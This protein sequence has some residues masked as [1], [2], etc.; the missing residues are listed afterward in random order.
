MQK[1]LRER[2]V[3]GVDEL[4]QVELERLDQLQLAHWGKAMAGNLASAKVVLGIIEQ[5][6]RLLGLAWTGEGAAPSGPVSIV[7]STV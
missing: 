6:S 2:V 5:R 3:E 1:A 4:R 7:R